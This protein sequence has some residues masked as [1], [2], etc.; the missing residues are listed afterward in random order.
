MPSPLTPA[1]FP[2]KRRR[3]SVPF[4]QQLINSCSVGDASAVKSLLASTDLDPNTYDSE[5]RIPFSYLQNDIYRTSSFHKQVALHF[6]ADKGHGAVVKL[7]L[8]D[9]RVDPTLVTGCGETALMIGAAR[10]HAPGL[11][12]FEE[13]WREGHIELE[14]VPQGTF[15]ERIRAGGAGIPAFFSPSFDVTRGR[16]PISGYVSTS[17]P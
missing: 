15:A 11:S 14:C 13:Q 16:S 5:I 3:L 6:A 4:E 9:R 7:L 12:V 8:S 1:P 10:G 2:N 17:P